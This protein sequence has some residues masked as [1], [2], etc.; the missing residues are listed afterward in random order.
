[1]THRVD[2]HDLEPQ[3]IAS[4]RDGCQRDRIPAFLETAFAELF[5]RLGRLGVRPSGPPLV[6]YHEFGVDAIDAEVCVPIRDV[7]DAAGRV[8]SRV[9]PGMTVAR[10]VHVGPYQELESAYATVTEWVSDH[11]AEVAGPL[12]ERYLNGPGD[13]VP[14]SEYRTVVELPIVPSTVTART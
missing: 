9:V 2:M 6:I 11:G 4:I 13:G 1:M 10:T 3:A 14:P 12:Q 8:R 7:I 5:Q